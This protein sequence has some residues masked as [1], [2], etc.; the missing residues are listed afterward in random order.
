MARISSF[1]IQ[2]KFQQRL[3]YGVGLAI[4]L[5]ISALGFAENNN[6]V[7]VEKHA[8]P[9]VDFTQQIQ[10]LLAKHCYSCH[11]PDVQEGGLRLDQSEQAFQQLESEATAIVPR[12]PEKSELIARITTKDDGLQ[13]PPEGERLSREQIDLLQNWIQQGAEWKKHWAFQPPQ[14]VTPPQTKNSKWVKTPIDAFIL[15]K[16]EEKGLSPAPSADRVTL[17]RR[18]Y[19]NLTGLPPAPEEVDQFVNDPAPDAYEKLVDRLLA[20]PRYGERWARH[21]LDLVRYADTN[22]FERD[23]VK[24]NAWRFRDY[25]IRSFNEDKPYNQF[26]KEQLAGDELD[27]VT[28]ETIIATGYYRLGLWDDEPAD[29][30]LGFYNELDDIV[31][32]T[33]QVFLGLT[34]NC[35]RCHEHKIDPVPH[36]DYYRFLAF[37]HGLNSYGTRG[38]QLSNNQTDITGPEI[39][40]QYAKYDAQQNELKQKMHQIEETGIKKMSGVDQRRSETRERGKLL[41][42]KLKQHLEPEQFQTYQG[43][44]REM[45]ELEAQRKKLPPRKMA[46]SVRHSLKEPRE[47]FVLL[48]GN[49]NSRGEKVEPG[50]PELFGKT[51]LQVPEP[52]KDQPTS[53]RRR[54]LAEWIASGDNMLTSRVIVNRVW[55]H[56]FGR[57]IVQSPNNFGQLGVPPTHPEL[58]DWLALEF[59]K[60]G[61]SFKTL[62]KLI[63]MS[64]AYQMSAQ[65][66]DQAAA[67]D[68]AN[69]LFWRFNMRRLSAEEVR[70]SILAVNGRLN[71]KMYGPGFYPEISKEVLQ[72]QS[73]PGHGWLNSSEE[74]RARRSIYIF[75]KRS[76]ITPLLSNF[77]FADTDSTCAVRFVTTQ[78]AQA[79]GMVNG[80]FVNRQAE[81][82]A[83]RII[84]ETGTAHPEFVARAIRLAYGRE[85]QTGEVTD[86]VRLID[87]LIKQHSLDE[88]QALNYF[89]LTILNRN[90][91]V[92]LD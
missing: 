34:L 45:K 91:F 57:G 59:V 21:W 17:I 6:K 88:K 36:E 33:S 10:P 25:V 77:D 64:N 73:K 28:N 24:P 80:A 13:M 52:R 69:D 47:T 14:K 63:M 53:G 90:E 81:L 20:S 55:Q 27:Q 5:G 66:S 54:A 85:A 67:I 78:P 65:Y 60:S 1:R 8:E 76:L 32:T 56:H 23:G 11:G 46:L 39:S 38:D 61:Q 22:S 89:C 4:V 84:E 40:A 83:D 74:E 58:L 70:D 75:V 35:A 26:I 41:K 49:P 86:G 2:G 42:E 68:P 87:T 12:H 50:F 82:F 29:P 48:R 3:S 51:K 62:H 31:S 18:A 79:L 30:L 16:L 15:A 72:G 7:T 92:Y 44:K 71:L 43:L 37:F 9:V 19:F